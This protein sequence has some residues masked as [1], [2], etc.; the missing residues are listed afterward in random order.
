VAH[1]RHL[2]TADISPLLI[3]SNSLPQQLFQSTPPSSRVCASCVG[4]YLRLKIV[5]DQQTKVACVEE[6]TGCRE[7]LKYEELKKVCDS[8]KFGVYDKA[9]A[10]ACMREET[11]FVYCSRPG[12]TS[13]Q[14]TTGD[15]MKC[16]SC[17]WLTCVHHRIKMHEGYTC[18]RH[19]LMVKPL[20]MDANTKPCPTCKMPIEKNGGC[21]HITCPKSYGGCGTEFCWLCAALYRGRQGIG[22]VGNSAHAKNCGHYRR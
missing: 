18:A 4:A 1:R 6:G 17:N 8:I 20:V 14:M 21:D 7:H 16:Q 10:M 11:D 5:G 13:G 19:D 12:C 3:W 9:L 15:I 2:P 22:T